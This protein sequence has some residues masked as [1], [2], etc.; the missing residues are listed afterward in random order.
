MPTERLLSAY[1]HPWQ[2]DVNHTRIRTHKGKSSVQDLI[3]EGS[4]SHW[5]CEKN[6]SSLRDVPDSKEQLH[7][8]PDASQEAFPTACSISWL[9]ISAQLESINIYSIR[10]P[11]SVHVKSYGACQ[12]GTAKT[13]SS[14]RL[15][16][17][18]WAVLVALVRYRP[19]NQGKQSFH[20]SELHWNTCGPDIAQACRKNQNLTDN[21]SRLDN[22]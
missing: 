8:R 5:S 14:H 4:F 18:P 1:L 22:S 6:N 15:Y 16:P 13:S 7:S 3:D 10:Y 2:Q 20:N 11:Q 12:G 17:W 9:E 21:S 19:Q